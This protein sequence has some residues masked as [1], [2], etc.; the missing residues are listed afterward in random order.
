[1]LNKLLA[2]SRR[3]GMLQ[4]G[5]TVV[6]AVSGGA[7]SIALL[8]ALYLL[9]EKLQIQ[10]EAAHFNHKLR[11]DESDADEQFVRDFCAGYGI[12]LHVGA[13]QVCPGKKG[14]EAAARE[15]RYSFLKSLPDRKI[16]TAHTADD[17]AETMLM[18]MLR[19]SGLKG[20]GGIAPVN[21]VLIRPLLQVT[22]KEVLAF[23][24][25]YHLQYITDSSNN[26]DRFLRNR[27]RH[28]VMPLLKQENPRLA[29]NLSAM[30]LRLRQDESMLS[31]MAQEQ[32][33]NDVTKLRQMHP[34]LRSRVLGTLL[35]NS[36]IPEPEAEHIELAEALV[37]SEKTS[38]RADFPG[39]VA[40]GRNYDRIEKLEIHNALEITKL[41]IPCVL[42]LNEA[43]LRVICTVATEC[44]NQPDRF[45]VHLQGDLSLRSR[46]EGDSMRLSG[47]SKRLKKLFIDK[48]IPANRRALIPVFVDACGVVG[49]YGFGA[50]LDRVA[51]ELPAV[52]ICIKPLK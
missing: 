45:T 37:F 31:I 2:F 41:D 51:K 38:A 27:L 43:G 34:A 18:H 3:Y 7:D 12:T 44:V 52:E 40:V 19:G 25:E 23:L 8:F 22:R 9:R 24:K 39:N 13:S 6:C 46:C 10:L 32:Q 11:G 15:A 26:T 5:D 29:E 48:K 14:L 20:L 16:A 33:C 17:N 4:P 35:Q 36:G 49:A 30:A 28:H 1:M 21:G 47:G 50:N 42:D